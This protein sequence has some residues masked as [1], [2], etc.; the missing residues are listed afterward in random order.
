MIIAH[1]NLAP[2]HGLLVR[3]IK[4]T[5]GGGLGLQLIIAT[6]CT[7]F[8]KSIKNTEQNVQHSEYYDD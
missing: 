5:L 3:R 6:T 4:L 1:I 8:M 7:E 2:P